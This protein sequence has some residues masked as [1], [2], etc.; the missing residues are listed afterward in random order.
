VFSGGRGRQ[1]SELDVRRPT[2]DAFCEPMSRKLRTFRPRTLFR[3]RR[4]PS[5]W[6]ATVI[7][8]TAGAVAVLTLAALYPSR[9]TRAPLLLK[10][11]SI[12]ARDVL[13]PFTFAVRKSDEQL[14]KERHEA[15]ERV[16]PSF[17]LV[18][19]GDVD[20]LFT[21]FVDSANAV[22]ARGGRVDSLAVLRPRLSGGA[23]ATLAG[24]N[25]RE[26]LALARQLVLPRLR[27]RIVERQEAIGH[28]P[29]I[30]V[31]SQAAPMEVP[32][33]S[34][35]TVPELLDTVGARAEQEFKDDQASVSAVQELARAFLG[36]SLFYNPRD[37]ERRRQQAASEVSKVKGSILEGEAIVEAHRRV[38]ADDVQEL[39]SLALEAAAR[40]GAGSARQLIGQQFGNLLLVLLAVGLL[41]SYLA[42][43]QR[44]VLERVSHVLI[45]AA[46]LVAV[47]GSGRALA[48]VH[49][50]AVPLPAASMLVSMLF[51]SAFALAFS[52]VAS[53]LVSSHFA[54]DYWAFLLPLIGGF[55]AA[56]AVRRV[57]HRWRFYI[58]L[59]LIA[60]V[61][62]LG[63]V[64]MNL[65]LGGSGREVLVGVLWSIASA[66]GS[67]FFVM[68][69]LPLF[70][71]MSGLATDL[72]LLELS[73]LNR[74][75]LRRL[76]LEAPGTYHH[77]LLVGSLAE[78]GAREVAGNDLLAR[79]A[80]YYHDIGKLVKP[81]YF[82]ENLR[83]QRNPHTRLSPKMS[84]LIIVAHIKEG[85]QI[86]RKARIPKLIRDIIPQHHGTG[87]ISFFYQKALELDPDTTLA[88]H[89]FSYPGPKPQTKEA[90]IVMLADS[91]ESAT[92]TLA[93]PSV[94]RL[95]GMT[96]KV[97]QD[98]LERGQLDESDLTFRD[99][100][101]IEESFV[102][103]L[104]G[105]FHSR[106]DYPETSAEGKKQS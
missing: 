50:A 24:P 30:V 98:K 10:E 40:E 77:S 66:A 92:R 91:V 23:L 78:A 36:P 22:L 55:T 105:V 96:R 79:V 4:K 20:S 14:Q 3:L 99:L 64:T 102:S 54:F 32:A 49:P 73:D 85:L 103:V 1:S 89:D 44:R 61:L 53:V 48:A 21:A 11:G 6:L 51:G 104:T 84:A 31:L 74:P 38:T 34:L 80:S 93:E 97:I 17:D 65:I 83:G 15:A 52:L 106:I 12:A 94:S 68:G 47:V 75:L 69:T 26:V 101:S 100:R 56:Y 86:A 43:F 27:L 41:T 57:R 19:R 2:S 7:K 81:E 82:V 13:A 33:D 59:A 5:K 58:A 8:A 29:H 16:A 39:A 88:E 76:A 60:A 90:G 71:A 35:H 46:L 28:H 87:P 72:T 18:S 45:V 62:S 63:V 25:G 37:T 95:R 70:E 67:S 42:V 9:A